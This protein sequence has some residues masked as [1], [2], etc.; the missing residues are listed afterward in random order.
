MKIIE[1]GKQGFSFTS[2]DL[3]VTRERGG[4]NPTTKSN[5]IDASRGINRDPVFPGLLS[6]ISTNRKIDVATT[7]FS[8]PLRRS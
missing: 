7:P 1:I 6:N 8:G 5:I 2:L 4:G 3:R